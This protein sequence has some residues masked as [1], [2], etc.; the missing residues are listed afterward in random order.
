[1]TLL[2]SWILI[3]YGE[4]VYKYFIQNRDRPTSNISYAFSWES[5][6]QGYVFWYT[7]YDAYEH[8]KMLQKTSKGNKKD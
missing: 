4:V 6:P 7:M 5:T 3:N 8:F 1:M 2:E